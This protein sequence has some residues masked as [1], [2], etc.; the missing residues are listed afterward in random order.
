M[1]KGLRFRVQRTKNGWAVIDRDISKIKMHNDIVDTFSAREAARVRCQE[2]NT[3]ALQGGQ[4]GRP[5]TP[6]R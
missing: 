6:S 5:E 3:S 4:G 1:R 2:L